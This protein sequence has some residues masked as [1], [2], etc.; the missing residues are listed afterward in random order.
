M[1]RS[2]KR[3]V[4]YVV[5]NTEQS[6]TA[7][8]LRR[9]LK[10]KLPEYMVPSAFVQLEALPLT[11][12]GK[13]DRRALRAP[14][15]A[16]P[17]LEDVFVAPSTPEEKILSAI[18]A[19]VLSVEQVGINDNF[20]ALGGDSIRSIQV[21]SQAKEQGLSFSVQQLFQHQTIHE[22]VQE[23]KTQENDTTKLELTQPFSLI[24]QTGKQQLPNGLEDAYPL[25]ILQMGMIYHS[26]YSQ[27]SAVYHDIFSFHL[28]TPLD[29]QLLQVAVQDLVNH[30]AVLRTSFELSNFS[31]PLQ[32][33]H[34]QVEVPLQM[35]D[36]C[37]L[38]H[39]EQEEA[40]AAWF[41]AE[42]KRHFDWTHPPLVRF[43]VHRRTQETFNLALS[44][45]HA[46]LDGWSVASMMSELFKRYL[47][48]LDKQVDY[49]SPQFSIAFR[50]FVAL[51]QQAIA[52]SETQRYW[53][54]KLN[55]STFTKLPRWSS[56]PTNT[57]VPEIGVQEVTLSPEIFEGLK[58]LAQS[59]EVPLKSVLLAAHLRVLNF[60]SG[61]SD[62]L[63]GLAA[64]GRPEQ[65]DGERVLGLFLNTLPFR[66]QLGGGTWI[67]LVRQVFAAERE[68]LPH[69]RYPLA[70]IQRS[71]GGESLFETAFNFT[72]FHVYEQVLGL[73]NL[74]LVGGKFFEQTNFTFLAQFSVSPS[75]SEVGLNLKYD[76]CELCSEQI[77][78]ISDYYIKVLA[79]MAN[80]PQGRY[81]LHSLVSLEERHQLLVEWNQTAVEYPKDKCIHQLF[82]A[83]V[84]Q[85]PNAT[86]VIFGD[87]HL[88]YAELNARSNQLA[89][90]LQTLGV[91]PEVLVGLC[92]ERS[93][94][95]VVGML[96]ILKAGGAYVP[97]DPEY[98]QE[99]LSFMLEDTQISVLLTQ[100]KLV[101]K[102]PNHKACV[103]YLDTN[104]DLINQETQQ[105]PTTNIKADNLA[106]VMYTSGST[107]QP[108]GV[109]I[110]HRGVV[111]LVKQTDY[112][113]FSDQEVFL[114]VAPISFDAATFEIWGCLL[115]GGRLVIFPSNT[116]SINELGQV[117]EQYKVTTLWLTAGLFHLMV[118]EKIDALKPLRQLLAGGDILSVPHIHKFL[119]TVG[120]CQLINGYGP[121]E[122]TTFTCCYQ[123]PTSIS[124][125]VSVPIGRP[126]ANTQAY[127]LDENLQPVP[128]GVAGELH[129][130]GAGLAR[131]YLNRPEL[132]QEKFIPNPFSDEPHSR[133]YK[134][135]DLARYL[136]DGNIEYLGRIDNQVKIRGF[137]IELG[138]IETVLSQHGDVQVS[139]VIAREDTPGDKRLVA[140][141]V[142]HQDC[143]PTIS[144][145]RQ[146]LK[147]KLPE[148]MVPNAIVI[149][150][151]LPLTPN[152]KVDRRA[153]PA[154]DLQSDQKDKYVAPRNSN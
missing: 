4:A 135:G 21:L 122:N 69:R 18:W 108:K 89:H 62:V 23:L 63:T 134:T 133:L 39:S 43:F 11:A 83:Q 58:Q 17:E 123:I 100:E 115:N 27:D 87:Q 102:L 78:R 37:H 10:Q 86:A 130:G 36:W 40:L 93:L 80:Q 26:E 35:E 52:S 120:N 97:L 149:L 55:D 88:T 71:L 66:L 82:E 72:H 104:W 9:F 151:S 140:Y 85:T 91:R 121:T 128:V 141:V 5:P 3:L 12:N 16:R 90:Y 114:Q 32:L 111:R 76:V 45:H 148:Y 107:G 147:A 84:E 25:A 94:E 116:P 48:L 143:T 44:F 136:A 49:V 129:I 113:S 31:I 30:H 6:P 2:N 150:E 139:C 103:I 57:N 51:E 20:F 60:L 64:N 47:S 144:K 53:S 61:E 67:E 125:D 118:D 81:E 92:V 112:V 131:G 142:A 154:P 14:D 33:V 119:Q 22:L 101:N 28:K 34:Q 95:M 65:S 24:S 74:Q 126:I 19:K 137:R 73:D 132:T 105:N 145:L 46:I 75:S 56:I 38:N 70:E 152:G 1:N 98:P 99:R 77:N 41:E 42:K 96:G 15:T 106:Y 153:L 13:V 68:M 117:I 8:E 127:I 109:S 79:A 138:E 146:F 124:P 7:A 110:V 50:D 54:E 29:V 59:A